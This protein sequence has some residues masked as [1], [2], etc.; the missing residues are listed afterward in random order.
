MSC[1]VLGSC[2]ASRAAQSGQCERVCAVSRLPWYLPLLWK[3][4]RQTQTGTGLGLCSPS[5]I[6]SPT[7]KCLEWLFL[8]PPGWQRCSSTTLQSHWTRDQ[9]VC[10]RA[11]QGREWERLGLLKVHP[12]VVTAIWAFWWITDGGFNVDGKR[13]IGI[14]TMNV[15]FLPQRMGSRRRWRCRTSAR[16]YSNPLST[17]N[18]IP[19]RFWSPPSH[20]SVSYFL[21]ELASLQYHS[22]FM[23]F[24]CDFNRM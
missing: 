20:R 7:R 2:P 16:P 10:L 1:H 23:I 13:V 11:D 14:H 19:R 5:I 17:E 21:N 9:E 3:C 24:K 4:S 15:I 12:V 8:S 6:Q 22:M 18:Q